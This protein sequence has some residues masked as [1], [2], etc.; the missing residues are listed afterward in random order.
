MWYVRLGCCVH[1]GH[2]CD[3]R[4]YGRVCETVQSVDST[5][6]LE[7]ARISVNN[8]CLRHEESC[9]MHMV[10]NACRTSMNVHMEHDS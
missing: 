10:D 5:R 9:K 8:G 2:G 1:H 3:G 7:L 4:G 6:T